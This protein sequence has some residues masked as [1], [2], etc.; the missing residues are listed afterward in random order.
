MLDSLY[1]S[2][3]AKRLIFNQAHT[4]G[5]FSFLY[6]ISIEQLKKIIKTMP[7]SH[8]WGKDK[9]HLDYNQK[10]LLYEELGEPLL[11]LN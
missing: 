3:E 4:L 9:P 1:I 5:S 2:P 11:F 7:Y 8:A 6:L 10:C